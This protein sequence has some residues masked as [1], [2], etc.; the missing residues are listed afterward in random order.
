MATTLWTALVA[1]A[2]VIAIPLGLAELVRYLVK[3]HW[4]WWLHLLAASFG[5]V[6]IF[7]E[8]MLTALY[9]IKILRRRGGKPDTT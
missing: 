2:S 5:F 6:L 4:S 3:A 7:L 8:Y 9:Q 1:L